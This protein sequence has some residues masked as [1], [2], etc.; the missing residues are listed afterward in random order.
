MY[1][2]AGPAARGSACCP[3]PSCCQR[4]ADAGSTGHRGPP[5]RG[6]DAVVT[7][8]EAARRHGVRRGPIPTATSICSSPTT[9][10]PRAPAMST[11]S[12]P[13]ACRRRLYV[14]GMP[15][16]PVPRAVVDGA[17]R[18]IL[19]AQVT[20]LLADAVQRGLCTVG[21]LRSRS[22]P[23]N[24]GARAI[25]GRCSARSAPVSD[26]PQNE[27]PRRCGGAGSARA[28]VERRRIRRVAASSASRTL[29]GTTS[30][31]PGRSTR[32]PGTW[33]PRTTPASRREPPCSRPRASRSSH[34]AE[35]A[36][37]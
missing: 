10:S 17:R 29:G 2:R 8:I 33:L 21:Q 30:R 15:L 7:G 22:R 25:R 32:S 6:P 27:R 1:H 37:R 13:A 20:E 5:L 31:W 3:R 36:D 11:S 18:L 35:A 19:A 12:A 34:A 28:L 24:D 26:R 4:S 14:A 9:D 16:A 23:R